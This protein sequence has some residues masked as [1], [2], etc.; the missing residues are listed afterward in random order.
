MGVSSEGE[1]AAAGGELGA[2][3][4]AEADEEAALL[5][6]AKLVPGAMID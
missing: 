5:A 6:L 3:A 2:G 1:A 4:S